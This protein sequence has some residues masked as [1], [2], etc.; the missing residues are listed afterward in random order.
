VKAG[1]E[2]AA[3]A[4]A[5]VAKAEPAAGEKDQDQQDADLLGLDAQRT[6]AGEQRAYQQRNLIADFFTQRAGAE[7]GT[8]RPLAVV[9]DFLSKVFADPKSAFDFMKLDQADITSEQNAALTGFFQAAAAWA[10]TIESNLFK[11]ADASF[12]FNDMMQFFINEQGDIAENMKTAISYAAFSWVAE[13][14]SRSA[15]NTDA[16][17]NALLNRGE[18]E[19]VNPTVK[20]RLGTVG[21]RESVVINALGQRIVQALG[22]KATKDAPLNLQPQLEAAL[23]AHAMKLLLDR[24]I[25]TRTIIDGA[26][27]RQLTSDAN[28][29]DNAQF[30]FLALTRDENLKLSEKGEN[31]AKAVRGSKGILDKLFSVEPGLKMPATEPQPLRQ[32]TTKAGQ[33]VPRAEAKLIEQENAAEHRLNPDMWRLFSSLSQ[34]QVLAMAGAESLE[35]VHVFR[36][37]GLK[38]KN[39]GLAREYQRAMEFFG[40]LKDLAQPFFF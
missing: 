20:A 38:A 16:E 27:M 30:K 31:I 8:Q 9:K 22:L 19:L 17:I 29:R 33:E 24:G 39:D 37:A 2:A 18:D 26:E 34:E 7:T 10:K 36:R 1:D 35:G 5:P 21:S 11:R 25:L 15:L 6:P 12:Y 23:G 13:N 32:K 14:A 3:P 28:T 40:G 4:E